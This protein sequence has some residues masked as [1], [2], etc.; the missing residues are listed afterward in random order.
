MDLTQNR[1]RYCTLLARVSAAWQALEGVGKH[2]GIEEDVPR[3]SLPQ[4]VN[5]M[6]EG[7]SEIDG[8]H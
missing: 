1:A 6:D 4:A 5:F 7:S 2:K 8:Y 3:L